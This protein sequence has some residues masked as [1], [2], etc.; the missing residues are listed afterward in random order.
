VSLISKTYPRA[1]VDISTNGLETKL[2]EKAVEEIFKKS[3][4][5]KLQLD[6]ALDGIGE[7]HDEIRGVPGAFGRVK[8]TCEALKSLKARHRD[9][10][11][12]VSFT[13]MQR[14]YDRIYDVYEF[15]KKYGFRFAC[16]PTHQ[17]ENYYG[18]NTLTEDNFTEDMIHSI[19]EQV[20]RISGGYRGFFIRH[21]PRYLKDKKRHFI[22][23]YSGF[24]SAF[25][26]PYGNVFPCL[27][28]NEKIGNI[29]DKSFFEERWNSKKVLAIRKKIRHEQCPNCWSECETN[30]SVY[31][32]GMRFTY[33]NLLGRFL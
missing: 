2:V 18:D 14:N 31:L 7:M 6:V 5:V 22:P 15:T 4:E 33:W 25:I 19:E 32:D 1:S 27:Y 30:S 3:P 17:S 23:C 28:I 21:I 13:I 29:K 12:T 11:V 10:A 20:R 8:E 24:Y 9:M 16:R 26:D